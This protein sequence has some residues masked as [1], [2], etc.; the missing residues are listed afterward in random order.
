MGSQ[1]SN[2]QEASICL[3]NCLAPNRQQAITSTNAD[4]VHSH[5]YAAQGGDELIIVKERE[6]QTDYELNWR[7][8]SIHCQKSLHIGANYHQ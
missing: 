7:R 3:G 4:Q 5:I 2:W 8:L 6:L 1:E